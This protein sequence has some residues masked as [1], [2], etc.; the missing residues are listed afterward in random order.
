MGTVIKDKLLTLT[1]ESSIWHSLGN[2]SGQLASS[3]LAEIVVIRIPTVA[4]IK[5]DG[6]PMA[7][8]HSFRIKSATGDGNLWKWALTLFFNIKPLSDLVGSSTRKKNEKRHKFGVP[9]G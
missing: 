6:S 3:P 8:R 9:G 5:G 4:R 7:A 1:C 2:S